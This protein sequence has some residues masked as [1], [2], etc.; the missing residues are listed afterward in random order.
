MRRV[1][2]TSQANIAAGSNN[3]AAIV[4]VSTRRNDADGVTG[5][6]WFDGVGFAQVL[7]GDHAT[8]GR[9]LDRIRTDPRHSNIEL[10]CDRTVALPMF[11]GWSMKRP[12]DSQ[13]SATS[14]AFLIGYAKRMDGR[15]ARRLL[16][17]VVADAIP[18]E[19]G[20]GH[21]RGEADRD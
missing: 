11:G 16:E 10:V 18:T 8:V 5:M 19:R 7:E 14:E 13:E 1:I 17:I 12:D 6:L 21:F 15:A 20:R 2:Y 9:T 3:V 4:E